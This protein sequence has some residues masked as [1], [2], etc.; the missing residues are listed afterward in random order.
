MWSNFS[1]S[2]FLFLLVTLGGSFAI[3]AYAV[4]PESIIVNVTPA[5]PAPYEEVTISLSTYAANLDT[6]SIS[7][8]V[9]G[10]ST[11]SEIGRKSFTVNAGGP[12]SSITITIHIFLPD[13]Q[14]TKTVVIRP[15]TTTLLWQAEDS[16]VPP[17]YRGKA[18]PSTGSKIKVVAIPEFGTANAAP[19]PKNVTYFWKKDFDNEPE[20]SGYGKNSYTY[21]H[22]FLDGANNISV[23]A[24]TV[25][26]QYASSASVTV[27]TIEPEIVFYKKD[28][29]LG[30]RWES[31]IPPQHTLSGQEIIV[32]SPYFISPKNIM[33]PELAWS[34]YINDTPV[35]IQSFIKNVMPLQAEAGS[36]G[37]SKLKLEI[38]NTEKFLPTINKEITIQF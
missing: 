29:E 33:R 27:D 1:K 15:S 7:W 23:E 32:A 35:V 26:Q 12:G 37:L 28:P 19:N 6:V 36:S 21:I 4:S 5:T 22:D 11:L 20:A 38:E 9:N 34:W 24:M 8:I 13:G 16:Y 2:L 17:F 3:P 30:T 25:D 10:K 18:L 31:V 14:I